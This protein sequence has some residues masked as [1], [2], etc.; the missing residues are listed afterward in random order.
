MTAPETKAL[1]LATIDWRPIPDRMSATALAALKAKRLV[2]TRFNTADR[3]HLAV[4]EWRRTPR[5]EQ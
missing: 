1:T 4:A 3:S 2:E 5:P